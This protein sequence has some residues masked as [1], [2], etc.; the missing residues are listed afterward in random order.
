MRVA[1]VGGGIAG[2]A[3]AYRLVEAGVD[4]IVF[5]SAPRAGGVLRSESDAGWLHEH[6]ANAFLSGARSFFVVTR[7]RMA[8]E[9]PQP[10]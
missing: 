2:L 10:S 8:S 9:R 6:A 7:W 3:A 5:E 4:A 1:V